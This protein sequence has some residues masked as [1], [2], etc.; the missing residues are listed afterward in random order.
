MSTRRRTLPL[1][2]LLAVLIVTVAVIVS[3]TATADGATAEEGEIED[4]SCQTL[5]ALNLKND[6]ETTVRF[7]CTIGKLSYNEVGFVVSKSNS[8]PTIGGA[9]CYKAGTQTVYST[10]TEDGTPRTA[11]PG[12]YWVAVKL[13]N[14]PH[15]YFDSPLYVRAF[16]TDG[17][18]TRYSDVVGSFTI[19][20]AVGHTHEI[21]ELE[22]E[23]IGGTAAMNVVGTKIGH[24]SGCNLDN[25]T[26]YDATTSLEYK[27]WSKNATSSWI[28]ERQFSDILRGGKHFY[29]DASND[30]EGND[31]YA[32]FSI[33]WNETLLNFSGSND[34]GGGYFDTVFANGKTD[35]TTYTNPRS[36]AFCAL[37]KNADLSASKFAGAF[38][39]PCT[40]I[41]T[42]GAGN[43][44][45]N[46]IHD[47]RTY[48]DYP[49]LGGADP[50][51]PEYGWHRIGIKYH[52]DVTNLAA[53]ESSGAV[54]QYKLTVT[55]YIDGQLVS[56]LNSET[57]SW[58]NSSVYKLYKVEKVGDE[59]KYTDI[60]GNYYFLL[61]KLVDV[62]AVGGSVY[63]VDGD[64][65]VT[66]GHD[67]VHPVARIN[68]P[69]ARTE[70]VDG[71]NFN[72]AFYYTTVGAHDHDWDGDFTVVKAATLLAEGVKVEHCTVCGMDRTAA[73]EFVPDVQKFTTKGGAYSVGGQTLGTVRENNGD[74]EFSTAGNDLL[75]EYSVLWNESCLN[76][77][78]AGYAD[79]RLAGSDGTTGTTNVIFWSLTNDCD[80]S[81][82]DYA[83]GFEWGGIDK[84]EQG[85]PYPKMTGNNGGVG[86]GSDYEDFPNIGGTD[87]DHPEWGW[88]RVQIR[89]HQELTNESNVRNNGATAQY[90]LTSTGYI[91][92][93]VAWVL[94]A[95][96]LKKDS[97]DR[98]LFTATGGGGTITYTQNDETYLFPFYLNNKIAKSGETVYFEIGDLFVTIGSDFVQNVVRIDNPTPATLEV[99][100]GVSVTSTMWYRLAD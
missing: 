83:G 98:K 21:R 4:F 34:E 94:S 14:I 32:E 25:V 15:S 88:H 22:Y 60:N 67:F 65:F 93:D 26:Q 80:L 35:E 13:T 8:T 66:A 31:L 28:D 77:T 50:D 38:E 84:S 56:I 7:V 9:N 91:D 18:G 33:L 2:L 99:E 40:Q 74:K 37:T 39:Y 44:Y 48:S 73:A 41:Q 43:P 85:N 6:D 89:V 23:M 10:I 58:E 79:V 82:C 92:G 20:S 19:C 96:D 47:G 76:L 71:H 36:I 45:P 30:Y 63:F 52:E 17:E 90:K 86:V 29:P 49:N 59:L 12:R 55:I 57:V 72:G 16:V 78:S 95:T 100:T 64:S 3:V 42:S 81:D 68:Y 27:R 1:L 75:I 5:A 87:V 69:A 51:H 62:K 46:M 70:T 24:C 61:F 97:Y 54:A 11:D 53:V